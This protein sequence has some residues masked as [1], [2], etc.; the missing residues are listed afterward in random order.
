MIGWIPSTLSAFLGATAGEDARRAIMAGA[1]FDPDIPFRLDA[2]YADAACRRMLD[3]ACAHLGMTEEAAFAAFAPYFLARTREAFPG[4]FARRRDVRAFLLHQPEVHNTLAA[5]LREGDRRH[6]QAKFRVEST[7]EGARMFYR[8]ANRLAGLYAAVA[9]QVGED[10]GQSV[11]VAF[12]AGTPADP[13][14]VMA[15]AIAARPATVTP[16]A[17]RVAA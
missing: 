14:C 3:I 9:R 10:C 4:F 1:G 12:E 5:G 6:V 13:E 8:S 7:P 17:G 11:A 16:E 2:S 15:I